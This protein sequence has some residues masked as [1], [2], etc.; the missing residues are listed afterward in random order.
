MRLRFIY[1]VLVLC[2][3][4]LP[5]SAQTWEVYDNFDGPLINPNLW[6]GNWIQAGTSALEFERQIQNGQLRLWIRGYGST[7]TD[8]DTNWGM[9]TVNITRPL[10]YKG[11]RAKLTV[12]RALGN[13]PYSQ[14]GQINIRTR[15]FNTGTSEPRDAA[16]DIEAC[17]YIASAGQ[18]NAPLSVGGQL[19]HADA[20]LPNLGMVNLGSVNIGET[21]YIW[22]RWDQP[23]KKVFFGFQR[24]RKNQLP[25]EMAIDYAGLVSDILPPGNPYWSIWAQTSPVSNTSFQTY[26]DTMVKIDQVSVIR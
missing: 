24:N 1:V 22:V 18:E 10:L 14:S 5:L 13:S 23:N 20:S 17:F 12:I 4:A 21:V 11:L 16:N 25:I 26:S 3:V 15:L 8:G 6:Y 19:T 7:F 9:N 2:F